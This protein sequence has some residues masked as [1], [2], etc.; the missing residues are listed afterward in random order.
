MWCTAAVREDE[1]YALEAL[2]VDYI[3]VIVL[4]RVPHDVPIEETVAAMAQMV[5]GRG[6]RGAL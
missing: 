3:D 5:G 4:C 1:E 2:G 6:G